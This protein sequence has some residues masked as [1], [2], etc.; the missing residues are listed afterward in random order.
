MTKQDIK[1]IQSIANRLPV[2]YEQTVSGYYQDFNESGEEQIF[3]NLVNHEINHERRMKKAFKSL[4]MDGIKKY[5]EY[6]HKLQIKRNEKL[7]H[8]QDT[9]RK[10]E[11]V[12]SL[13]QGA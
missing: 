4:G 6:I 10:E 9:E 5:L 13:P 2:V 1:Y 7:Q 11:A 3:P 8:D 12:D